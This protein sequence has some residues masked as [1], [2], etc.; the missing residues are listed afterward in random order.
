MRMRVLLAQA[1]ELSGADDEVIK[2]WWAMAAETAVSQH[3]AL[4]MGRKFPSAARFGSR[5]FTRRKGYGAGG[6][7]LKPKWIGGVYLGPARSVPG[8]HMVY[9]D[10]GNLWFTTNICQFEECDPGTDGASG[11]ASSP[12]DL[13]PARRVRGKTTAVELA[14]G[15]S[16]LPGAADG[17]PREDPAVGALS[18]LIGLANSSDSDADDES[19]SVVSNGPRPCELEGQVSSSP[20]TTS[21]RGRNGFAERFAKENRYSMEDCLKV[22]ESEPFVKTRK[23]RATAWGGN[24]PPPI[25]TTLGAYQRGPHVGVTNATGRHSALSHYLA[26]FMKKSCGE[27]C[28]FT[29]IT[30][31]RDLCTDVHCDRF[32]MRNSTNY[33][34]T[35]GEFKGGG[36]WQQG[37]NAEFADV[38]VETASGDVLQGHVI[39]VKDRVVKVDPK[40]LHRTMPWEGGPKWTVIAHTIGARRNLADSDVETLNA[41]GFPLYAPSVNALVD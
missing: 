26:E 7:D 4:A 11:P 29:S 36:I 12:P 37:S 34:L 23:Q 28:E 13:L 18:S 27:S 30:V 17:G 39:P 38:A 21:S 3:Q 33:V 19:W 8:G 14:S 31:A 20:S 41:L 35:L 24:G 25:H 1:K 5:V 16:L 22:L 9:T 6:T 10:E 32:N 15:A 40:R 2:G